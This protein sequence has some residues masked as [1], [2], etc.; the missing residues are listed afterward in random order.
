MTLKLCWGGG[1]FQNREIQ[2]QYNQNN[3][4]FICHI[5]NYTEYSQ[6][7]NMSSAFNPSKCTH[8]EQWAADT[9]A[10]GEQLGVRC[11]AQGSHLSRGQ[12]LEPRFEPK[13]SGYKSN[14]LSIRPRLPQK[15]QH[16][17]QFYKV[18]P[19][20]I[21]TQNTTGFE[22]Q[23]KRLSKIKQCS[24]HLITSIILMF[25]SGKICPK[26]VVLNMLVLVQFFSVQYI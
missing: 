1:G 20:G 13:T 21:R 25:F 3:F 14:A 24:R 7:W 15:A 17:S 5:H 6:Q 12:F 2:K 10:P 8:L 22:L 11:L 16:Y 26:I 18:H 9:A 19:R 4:V 23:R